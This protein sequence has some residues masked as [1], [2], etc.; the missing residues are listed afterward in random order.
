MPSCLRLRPGP[1]DEVMARPPAAAAPCT[2]LMAA[3]SLSAWINVPST[4]GM[5]A[6]MY[7]VRSFCGVMGYP[8]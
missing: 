7:S 6:D 2:R 8:K 3:S 1:D 4:S 5:R